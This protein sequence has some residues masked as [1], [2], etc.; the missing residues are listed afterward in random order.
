MSLLAPSSAERAARAAALA[1]RVDAASPGLGR[2]W[3]ERVAAAASAIEPP[4]LEAWA[5]LLCTLGRDWRGERLAHALLADAGRALTLFPDDLAG[6]WLALARHLHVVLD[7]AQVPA[8]LPAAVAT[9]STAERR[10]WL[11]AALALEPA[12]ALVVY[13]DIPA[14]LCELAPRDRTAFFAAIGRAAAAP[15]DELLT[16]LPMA[17][18]LLR[19][20]PAATRSLALTLLAEVGETF[21]SGV[22][23]VLRHLPRLYDEA[24]PARVAEW[25]ERGLAIAARNP[26]AGRA[27]FALAS[28]TSLALLRASTTAVALDEVQGVLR[29]F[30]HMLSGAPAVPRPAGRFLLRPP[31]ED[32]PDTGNIALPTTIDVGDTW[33]DNARFYRVC[34]ALLAGR[35][36]HGTYA[37]IPAL[38]QALRAPGRPAALE[39]CFLLADGVRVAHAL[40]RQYPG[41]AADLRW[42]AS[43]LL[44]A[45]ISRPLS[46]FEL[47]L[48]RALAGSP[49]LAE[50]SWL[51]RT[52]CLV[53]PSLAP[54]AAPEATAADAW[55]VAERLAALFPPPDPGAS[56]TIP[57]LATLLLD[58]GDT[59]PAL[60]GGPSPRAGPA[61]ADDL[62]EPLP[63]E[64]LEELELVLDEQ[65]AAAS[66]GASGFSADEL[67]RLLEAGIVGRLGQS[68]GPVARQAGLFVTQLLGKRLAAG[69]ALRAPTPAVPPA[70]PRQAAGRATGAV[71]Q[72]DEWDYLIDDYRPAWCTLREIPLPDD[73]GVYFDRALARHAALVPEIRRHLQR[74]R[75]EQYR[76]L[77]GLEAGEDIDLGALVDARAQRRARQ[78]VSPKL[79]TARARQDRE[80]ATLFLLDMSA[81]TDETAP[82]ARERIIDI[83]KDA[84]VILATALEEL[85][86]HYA[87]Y[88]FSGQGRDQVEVY[89][90]KRFEER[91]GPAAQGRLGSIEP[92]G[93]TRMGAALRHALRAMQGLA[94]PARY[95][96]LL[97][98]GFPQDLDYGTDRQSHT[99]GIRDTAVALR[100]VAAAGVRPFC[101]TVDLAGHDYLREMC[102][103]QAYVVIEEVAALPQ[104]LPK[105]YQRLVRPS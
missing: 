85:G 4:T 68:H 27:F 94:A 97:S 41:L 43:E 60:D 1:A 87:I 70:T 26:E 99:Y 84:L 63:P 55:R 90:V 42:A 54:L 12:A 24:T 9:W 72:Y 65:L 64:L 40:G 25:A 102:D 52:A 74:L 48:A 16:V 100:E 5:T 57:E 66:D 88:G 35:R 80:V 101:I 83:A 34:A 10:A 86:D 17:P 76:R 19:S 15:R 96:V 13:R 6:C 44:R 33:E 29:R 58:V 95:L 75:P 59:G 92:R 45:A 78:A 104:E 62:G 31:L 53:L 51:E 105:I 30:V 81:S 37:P 46:V 67:R 50:P 8:A 98:D 61:P 22:P 79:Y 21:P 38:V 36:V 56:V 103:P 69:L 71:Y 7:E 28:R 23:G 11:K 73:S 77:R 20:L 47:L 82:S 91:L 2:L 49:P 93:S 39:D 32:A 3:R 89:P 14:R 18:A